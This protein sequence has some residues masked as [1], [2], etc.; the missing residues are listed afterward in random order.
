M[1]DT[2]FSLA[3]QAAQLRH[4]LERYHQRD[5]IFEE[6]RALR[7]IIFDRIDQ[8]Y[9]DADC[10]Q[11]QPRGNPPGEPAAETITGNQPKAN[12]R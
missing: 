1:T 11:T 8:E 2:V 4:L 9:N 6:Y 12:E 3:G 10:L 7:K 5:I